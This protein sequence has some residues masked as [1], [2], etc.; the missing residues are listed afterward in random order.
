MMQKNSRIL[1]NLT[2][3]IATATSMLQQKLEL[4]SYKGI[5][6]KAAFWLLMQARQSGK[7]TVRIPDSVSKWAMIMHV[8]RPSLHRKLTKLESQGIIIYNPP[9]IK[10]LDTKALYDV[11]DQ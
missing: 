7:D 3:E 6:Q 10:L 2:A 5:A 11:L 8:S 9:V 4:L 1:T